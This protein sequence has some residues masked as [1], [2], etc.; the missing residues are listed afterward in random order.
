M[1]KTYHFVY[2]FFT[3]LMLSN[4]TL[5]FSFDSTTPARDGEHIMEGFEDPTFPPFGWENP[6]DHWARF[7]T[8][9]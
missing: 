7:T 1:K 4:V 5:L 2:I 9:A 3:I 8:E 6:G